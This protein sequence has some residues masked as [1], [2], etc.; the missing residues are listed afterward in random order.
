MDARTAKLLE[1]A[2]KAHDHETPYMDV[3]PV[4]LMRILQESAT[5]MAYALAELNPAK[6]LKVYSGKP[7][8]GCGC[9]GTYY[10][11]GPMLT[12]ITNIIKTHAHEAH[13]FGTGFAYETPTR[14]YW[15]YIA[16]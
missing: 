3:E 9:R 11:S 5:L 12:K 16:D 4:T 10:E 8:C 13:F 6:V 7:G 2:T 14:Y 1:A 15:L